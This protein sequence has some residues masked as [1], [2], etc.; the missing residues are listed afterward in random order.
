MNLS[1]IILRRR[2]EEKKPMTDGTKHGTE[3]A[4]IIRVRDGNVYYGD[5]HAAKSVSLEI[6]TGETL[7]MIGPSGCGKSH[8]AAVL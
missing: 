5:F 4:P 1:A 2:M 8:R 7:A 6:F 3:R